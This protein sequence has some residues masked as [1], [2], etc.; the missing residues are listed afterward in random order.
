MNFFRKIFPSKNDR[1]VKKIR[2]VVAQINEIELGLQKL[3]DDDLRA[4]T[5]AWKAELSKIEDKDELAAQARMKF[6]PRPL[7]W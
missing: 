4:K 3:S 7:P 1:D 2:P 5:A 6:C